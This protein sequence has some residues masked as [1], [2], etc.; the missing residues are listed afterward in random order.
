MQ[1]APF[2]MQPMQILSKNSIC[3]LAKC[4]HPIFNTHNIVRFQCGHSFHMECI[5]DVLKDPDKPYCDICDYLN[6]SEAAQLRRQKRLAPENRKEPRPIEI[7]SMVDVI[8]RTDI[9]TIDEFNEAGFTKEHLID[10]H[11]YPLDKLLTTFQCSPIDLHKKLSISLEFLFTHYPA[12]ELVQIG[13]NANTLIALGLTRKNISSIFKNYN[14]E[15]ILAQFNF[16]PD[17]L[18]Q[19]GYAYQNYNLPPPPPPPPSPSKNYSLI[20]DANSIM[21][22]GQQ[23]IDQ[24][25]FALRSKK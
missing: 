1:K 24:K 15:N 4:G 2:L 9:R 19:L 21:F 11:S 8:N 12:S 18:Q 7:T 17:Q 3:Q 14:I 20:S 25:L 22:A 13:Y 23:K 6:I 16:T 5:M 10:K